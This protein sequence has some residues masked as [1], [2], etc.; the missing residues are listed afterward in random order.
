MFP[1]GP[2]VGPA[3]TPWPTEGSVKL[4]LID[5]SAAIALTAFIEATYT[6]PSAPIEGPPLAPTPRITQRRAPAAVSEYTSP[7]ELATTT[8]PSGPTAGGCDTYW[9]LTWKRHRTLPCEPSVAA[10]DVAPLVPAATSDEN[11][12]TTIAM[13]R[14]AFMADLPGRPPTLLAQ[15]DP[16]MTNIGHRSRT[17]TER[18]TSRRRAAARCPPRHCM[19]SGADDGSQ[20]HA[21]ETSRLLRP[22]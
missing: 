4:H 17:S 13:R 12:Q 19:R 15:F 7:V 6:V 16:G 8:P 14:L 22:Y 3:I 20:Q 1:S 10:L 21:A 5:P 11:T 2:T 18:P 9:P